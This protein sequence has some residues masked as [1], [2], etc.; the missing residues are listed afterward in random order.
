MRGQL[1]RSV[2]KHDSGTLGSILQ[3]LGCCPRIWSKTR[4]DQA[5]FPPHRAC[6]RQHI[7]LGHSSFAVT[8]NCPFPSLFCVLCSTI[9]IHPWNAPFVLPDLLAIGSAV[10]VSV[11]LITNSR[12]TQ[13]SPLC[14]ESVVCKMDIPSLSETQTSILKCNYPETLHELPGNSNQHDALICPV[15]TCTFSALIWLFHILT[16]LINWLQIFNDFFADKKPSNWV[17]LSE[18][19]ISMGAG[20]RQL[21]KYLPGMSFLFNYGIT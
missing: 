8:Q 20:K 7:L 9:G 10:G 17:V 11:S 14:W 4:W 19:R 13:S 12:G 3:N 15:Y 2:E 1:T 21:S 6:S 5:P 18:F 16:S